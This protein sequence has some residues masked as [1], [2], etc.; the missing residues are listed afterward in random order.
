MGKKPR[1]SIDTV[2]A[3]VKKLQK[4]INKIKGSK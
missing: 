4:I 2:N 3:I 1:A